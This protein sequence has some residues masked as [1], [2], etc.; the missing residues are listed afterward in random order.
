MTPSVAVLVYADGGVYRPQR[1]W[2]SGGRWRDLGQVSAKVVRKRKGRVR[3]GLQPSA[4]QHGTVLL[5][6]RRDACLDL[7]AEVPH[8]A[9]DRPRGGVAQSANR[10]TFDLFPI[11]RMIRRDE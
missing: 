7:G 9:L 10:A 8:E 5:A 11:L 3:L 1:G 6:E 4:K 2:C